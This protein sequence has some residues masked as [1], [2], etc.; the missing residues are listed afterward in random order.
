LAQSIDS[1][2]WIRGCGPRD[3]PGVRSQTVAQRTFATAPSVDW[4][5]AAL[6]DRQHGLVTARQ[7][8]QIG[9]DSA[10]IGRRVRTGRLHRVHRGVYSVG[11]LSRDAEL[12][13]VAL[14][15]GREALISHWAG[16]E[17]LGVTR[18]RAP[19]T[20]DACAARTAAG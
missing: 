11:P 6:A 12:M 8:A 19:V 18:H 15:G 10:A 20:Q 1:C 13:A 5:I 14:A 9:V 17:L 7:L 16:A 2:V 4:A 3:D